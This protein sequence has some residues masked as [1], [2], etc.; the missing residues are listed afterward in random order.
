MVFI[1]MNIE[2]NKI[3]LPVGLDDSEFISYAYTLDSD[4]LLFTIEAWDARVLKISFKNVIY[5]VDKSHWTCTL[6]ELT[7]HS[8]LLQEALKSEYIEIPED[9]PYKVYQFLDL[10]DEPS[11]E[12]ICEKFEVAVEDHRP[13]RANKSVGSKWKLMIPV[14][15]RNILKMI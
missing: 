13:T 15:I 3:K 1:D 12:I 14:S 6:C 8:D 4:N 10:Y 5:F 9:H 7:S 11:F 2:R